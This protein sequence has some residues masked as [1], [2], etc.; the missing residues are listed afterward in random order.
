[1]A[2]TFVG[3]VSGATVTS[4][5]TG[6]YLPWH[7]ARGN[8]VRT[9]DAQ[10]PARLVTI[11]AGDQPQT[12]NVG[13]GTLMVYSVNELAD[14]LTNLA[15]TIF[16]DDL[17][18]DNIDDWVSQTLDIPGL[19]AAVTGSVGELSL[20]AA[21]FTGSNFTYTRW[22]LRTFGE[23]VIPPVIEGV[24]VPYPG[25]VPIE[26]VPDDSIIYS[27]RFTMEHDQAA[28]ETVPTIRLGITDALTYQIAMTYIGTFAATSSQ[29]GNSQWPDANT[30][31]V[32]RQYWANNP[33]PG[34]ASL[35]LGDGTGIING[36]GGDL[37]NFNAFW[38]ILNK[39]AD[40]V[41]T[42]T[43]SY[44]EVVT[45]PRPTTGI[46]TSHDPETD[47]VEELVNSETLK[48]TVSQSGGTMAMTV[49]P[50]TVG[51][52]VP[53]ILY[54]DYDAMQM[55]PDTLVRVQVELSC[56]TTADRDNFKQF[57]VRFNAPFFQQDQ[58][59]YIQQYDPGL[60]SVV[61]YP[62]IPPSQQASAGATATYDVY[63]PVFMTDT[64]DLQGINPQGPADFADYFYLGLDYVGNPLANIAASTV[65]VHSVTSE[66]LAMPAM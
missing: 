12:N 1:M 60:A 28:R 8:L 52:T 44:F 14:G 39:E 45:M 43:M 30:P 50:S 51:G 64:S 35:D 13:S 2:I 16:S 36:W 26:Y 46:T 29:T 22:T 56:P 25:W 54:T 27:A 63:M 21:Q 4:G 48:A 18:G 20:T 7:N 61:G 47:F 9:P 11:W 62:S 34:E 53:W 65:T 49:P 38:D 42:L 6:I 37:R 3:S 17:V 57:R 10:M 58:L 40:G 5:E 19:G 31:R 59:Y 23:M 33:G 32:Y 24:P 66:I 15:A 55:I 41:G